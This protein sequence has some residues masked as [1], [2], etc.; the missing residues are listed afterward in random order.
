MTKKLLRLAGLACCLLAS[1]KVED[2]DDSFLLDNEIRIEVSGIE[3]FRY[4]PLTCQLFCNYA[5]SSFYAGT[6]TMSDFFSVKLDVIPTE[7]EQKVTGSIKWTTPSSISSKDNVALEVV[8]L[9]GDK[10]WLWSTSSR[11]GMVIKI[12]YQ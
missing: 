1:C 3:Y 12:L 8:R 10:I 7:I 6:D 5:G 11:V 9:E 2:I 4:D